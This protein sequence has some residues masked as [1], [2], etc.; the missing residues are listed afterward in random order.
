MVEKQSFMRA[1]DVAKEL[2]P[3]LH[4]CYLTITHELSPFFDHFFEKRT[5]HFRKSLRYNDLQFF[6]LWMRFGM[7]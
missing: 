6:V 2:D 4:L 3:Y 5:F 1:E 7:S